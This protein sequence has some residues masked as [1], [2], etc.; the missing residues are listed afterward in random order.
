MGSYSGPR[1]LSVT[2]FLCFVSICNAML[3][4]RE[5]VLDAA[6]EVVIQPQVRSA[7]AEVTSKVIYIRNGF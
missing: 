5:V 7:L 2:W 4:T 3:V 6:A 1:L